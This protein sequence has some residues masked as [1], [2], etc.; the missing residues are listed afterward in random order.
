MARKILNER[1]I[2]AVSCGIVATSSA[3]L[4]RYQRLASLSF[5]ERS[6]IRVVQSITLESIS[7]APR[8]GS[9]GTSTTASDGV[10]SAPIHLKPTQT[11]YT[12][13]AGA[14]SVYVGLSRFRPPGVCQ[15]RSVCDLR[16]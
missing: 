14:R 8:D 10:E 7:G 3:S 13:E 2:E 16:L 12:G 11:S 6:D 1:G 5:L 4:W 9:G 15:T